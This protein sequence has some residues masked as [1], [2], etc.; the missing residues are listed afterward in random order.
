MADIMLRYVFIFLEKHC[1]STKCVLNGPY[2]V[3]RGVIY[4]YFH[5]YHFQILTKGA[6]LSYIACKLPSSDPILPIWLYYNLIPYSLF[7]LLLLSCVCCVLSCL[8][9]LTLCDPLDHSPPRSSVHGILQARI[10]KWVVMSSSRGTSRPR[11]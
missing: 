8:S 4:S 6:R 10:L 1:L 3:V 2:R 5:I 9:C 11:D 7:I